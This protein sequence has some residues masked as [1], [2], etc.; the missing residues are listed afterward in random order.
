MD[1]T[2]KKQL[3]QEDASRSDETKHHQ[4]WS[5]G[6]LTPAT[7]LALLVTIVC[8]ASAFAG[9]R[10]GLHGYTPLHL[11]IL[12]YLV[13][14][15]IL[16]GYA[17]HKRMPLPRL[18]DLSGIAFTGL[19]GISMYNFALNTGELSVSAGVASV[20]VNTAP[21]FTALFAFLLLHERLSRWGWG[22]IGV[23]FVGATMTALGTREGLHVDLRSLFVL[24]AALAQ[25]IYF[26]S[27]KP[28]LKRYSAFQYTTYAI[29]SGTLFLLLFSVGIIREVQLAPLN[30][31]L[32]TVYLGVF[33]GAI[34]Y[35][36]W[37][38][39]LARI[40]AARAASF[41]YLV[42][43]VAIG[44]AWIWLGEFP[45]LFALLGGGLV[46]AGVILVNT[47]GKRAVES[48]KEKPI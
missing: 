22:G 1:M 10:T 33:P 17:L 40:P 14:S 47:R 44:I 18:C 32:A 26:V 11:A 43:P 39:A 45:T 8:W 20:L 21:I 24:V 23:S 28:Y 38:Y 42:P 48:H 30:A 36:S 31:T 15:I 34:A 35:V 25:S 29:W 4:R 9:I 13:A 46:I 37:A 41:L 2:V 12:R 7:L 27:Q 5:L 19:V 16:G 6:G 3:I